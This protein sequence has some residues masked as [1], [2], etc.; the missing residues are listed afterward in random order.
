MSSTLES[1]FPTLIPIFTII[2]TIVL[3]LYFLYL[4]KVDANKPLRAKDA[5]STQP[6]ISVAGIE[7]GPPLAPYVKEGFGL[8]MTFPR[9]S[10]ASMRFATT[11]NDN[12]YKQYKEN[13][14]QPS[15]EMIAL[16]NS[17][18]VSDKMVPNYGS[19]LSNFDA[20]IKAIPWDADNTQYLQRD[21][22]WGHVSHDASASIF[23]KAYHRKLLSDPD[24]LS[25]GDKGAM[26][27]SPLLGM[28]ATNPTSTALLQ[29]AE[30]TV[31]VVGQ[32]PF[33]AIKER[34][35]DYVRNTRMDAIASSGKLDNILKARSSGV[36]SVD[37]EGLSVRDRVRVNEICAAEDRQSAR[38]AKLESGKAL[39]A[40]EDIEQKIYD[41]HRS[42]L[43]PDKP[44][45]NTKK[46]GKISKVLNQLL[47][48]DKIKTGAKNALKFM[49]NPRAAAKA[50]IAMAKQMGKA[51]V[52]MLLGKGVTFLL[53]GMCLATDVAAVTTWGAMTPLAIL[54]HI[55]HALWTTLDVV[56]TIAT[57]ALQVLL[58][59]LMERAMKNG[60][61][62]TEGKPFDHLIEDETLYFIVTTFIPFG[63]V[64][65][66]F[67]PYTCF[68]SD[69]SIILKTPLYIPQYFAD[70]SLSTYKHQYLPAQRPRGDSTYFK[71]YS[72]PSGW[73]ITAGIAR[74]PC[75]PGTWTSSDIDMLCNISTYIPETYVKKARI[76]DVKAKKSWIPATRGKD[77]ILATYSRGWYPHDMQ[78]CQSSDPG[79][80][81]TFDS[82]VA[83]NLQ[84][85]GQGCWRERDRRC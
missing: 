3:I 66:A 53:T 76:P 23:L 57:I 59:T 11:M 18:P 54:A 72:L 29:L 5:R 14:L 40:A 48:A 15:A 75:D 37:Y 27:H 24:N 39:S 71:N 56:S 17:L 10:G 79:S 4:K 84:D 1:L 81:T 63:P 43:H 2:I 9:W 21:V 82:I 67:G 20:D 47:G 68:R 28:D 42:H 50:G 6:Y 35:D 32:K 7:T 31:A 8:S 12:Y 22:V 52:N 45:T 26:Y 41:K 77:A 34:L 55:V 30:A 51:M 19:S 58:P 61:I 65:D 16:A 36:A 60:A 83:G 44:P 25:E 85:P 46:P 62:C 80:D 78:P 74:G 69:G 73:K 70:P 38:A 33:D 49:K 13:N 64:M